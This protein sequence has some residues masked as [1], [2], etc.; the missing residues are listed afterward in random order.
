M[1]SIF[2]TLP[3]YKGGLGWV[4][5]R[6]APSPSGRMHMGNVYSALLSW[7]SV[8]SQG[9]QWLLRIEDLDPQRCKRDYALQLEED[10]RWLGLD[11]DAGG[12]DNPLYV[13]SQRSAIY[14]EYLN[15]LRDLELTYPCYCSRA[16]I[17]ATQAPHESDGRVV[18]QG[19]CRPDGTAQKAALIAQKAAT[20]PHAP[21]TRLCVPN[22]DITF[23]D[24]HYGPQSINL[25]KECGDFILRRADGAWAYQLA[26]VVDDA[27]MGVTEV[28]R[29]R[30]LLQSVP[31]QLYLYEVLGFKAPKF[32]HLPL[33]CNQ[34]QQ[35]LCKRDHSLHMGVLREQYSA[36]ELLG[37]I[38]H[39]A[40]L[41]DR[42]EALSAQELIPLFDWN[43]IPT[44]DIIL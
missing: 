11:W 43:K 19:T 30:D 13:Q 20:C 22:R 5:G 38:A 25:A 27:L 6:F 2:N 23:V 15:R 31:Q 28:I 16:D 39:H 40:G 34:Q 14:E 17:L 24:G 32:A 12:I 7:L 36:P 33:L 3:P 44:E 41:I 35:R 9:G 4:R 26:V 1:D 21:A 37:L 29:G 8:R 42:P 10:L 18:Y